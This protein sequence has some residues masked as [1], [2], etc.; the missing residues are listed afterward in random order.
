MA[1][2]LFGSGPA[3]ITAN[4]TGEVIG[5]IE[6][7][8]YTA[9]SGGVRITD[10]L[11]VDGTPLPGTVTSQ[12]TADDDSDIGRIR[13]QAP[14]THYVLYLDRGYGDRWQV[15]PSKLGETVAASVD[16]SST[17][18]AQSQRAID[19]AAAALAVARAQVDV[20]MYGAVGDGVTDDTQAFRDAIDAIELNGGGTLFV[21]PL[22]YRLAGHI[23]LCSSL[24]VE[25]WGATFVKHTGAR[26][27]Y[28]YFSSLSRGAVGY[29]SGCRNVRVAGITFTGDFASGVDTCGFAL[30]HA[31]DVTIEQC[32]FV[33]AQ[34]PGHC[35]D[36]AGCDS[37]A[38][39][40]CRFVGHMEAPAGSAYR[41][42][43]AIQID[44]SSFGS[45]SVA[46][47]PG[48]HDGK[49]TRNVVVE[50][51]NFE[52]LLVNNVVYPAPNPIGSHSTREG[53][54][55]E[56]ITLRRCRIERMTE[57]YTSSW[58]GGIHFTGV[59][60]LIVEN[61]TIITSGNSRAIGLYTL[62]SGT[63]ATHDPN[64]AAPPATTIAPIR[65]QN[66]RIT[67]NK[68][69]VAN[70]AITSVQEL[71]FIQGTVNG[72]VA[73]MEVSGN[74]LELQTNVGEMIRIEYADD[75]TVR[76]NIGTGI[77]MGLVVRNSKRGVV[78]GNRWVG[79]P[80]TPQSFNGQPTEQYST[81][82]GLLVDGEAIES[83]LDQGIWV[84]NSCEDVTI[85]GVKI[86]NSTNQTSGRGQ[87]ISIA[88]AARFSVSGCKL[89]TNNTIAK[90]EGVF[91]YGGSSR[92]LITGNVITGFDALV[93]TAGSTEVTATGNI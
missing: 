12:A 57:D 61:N 29:G 9:P 20:R 85:S 62:T 70:S 71:I 37:V 80:R 86:T 49:P 17:A 93:N 35:I 3:D 32:A 6:F 44:T 14:D 67:G 55:A 42:A 27:S 15:I 82:S 46:D 23:P 64:N 89:N 48:S 63:P 72:S 11:A 91:A 87:A 10:I 19:D 4:A 75:F 92:G 7:R 74:T 58:R 39:R 43:E 53:A 90:R 51:C 24:Y 81:V 78:A 83:P 28:A 2:T 16:A 31:Q 77:H 59:R 50:D 33:Q 41:R 65:V 26:T 60:D 76:D 8:V 56:N 30:H 18:L 68:I 5:G 66:A 73:G 84:G 52:S 47:E 21:P 54:V 13:F 38:I 36:L 45:L 88:S 79:S 25:G 22:R 1:Y 69:V 34:G 40:Q